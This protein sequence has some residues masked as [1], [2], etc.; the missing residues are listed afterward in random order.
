MT[1][2]LLAT[3][4]GA[5]LFMSAS[6]LAFAT[7]LVTTA[8]TKTK[9]I[10]AVVTVDI[11]KSVILQAK[12]L[13]EVAQS[14]QA[15][16]T[17]ND[18]NI[19]NVITEATSAAPLTPPAPSEVVHSTAL[20]GGTN[21]AGD[22][23]FG[24]VTGIVNVNQA[25]GNANNQGSAVAL[26]Y[27]S[28]DPEANKFLSAQTHIDKA[29]GVVIAVPCGNKITAVGS[30][31]NDLIGTGALTGGTLGAFNGAS[32]L[33]GVNQA[34]GNCNNQD[35]ATAI[36]VGANQTMSLAEAD[37]GLVTANNVIS[38][39]DVEKNDKIVGGAFSGASG[40][41]LVNQ[42]SGNCNN[43]GNSVSLVVGTLGTIYQ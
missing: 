7:V 18:S 31:R 9:G 38:E 16:V 20:L 27:A 21:A 41:M 13:A 15:D 8:V 34:S 14:A 43:Q 17:K 5:T 42:A 23:T 35:N 25:P 26:A 32:G 10:A 2:R 12:Q 3:A 24:G 29:I 19:L 11:T 30:I 36:A 1:K 33:V 39:K 40:V 28:L 6:G 22:V 4:L 37:L